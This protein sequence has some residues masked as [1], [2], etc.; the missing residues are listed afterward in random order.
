MIGRHGEFYV[1]GV[2]GTAGE[3]RILGG[4][5]DVEPFRKGGQLPVNV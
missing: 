4:E 1:Q 3:I 2:I 5:R